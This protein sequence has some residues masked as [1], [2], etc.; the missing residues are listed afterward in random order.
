MAI[1]TAKAVTSRMKSCS[2]HFNASNYIFSELECKKPRLK[3][4]AVPKLRLPMQ[5][6]ISAQARA[7]RVANREAKKRNEKKTN[8]DKYRDCCH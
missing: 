3:K 7:D 8:N 2:L 1:R 5:K 6:M 4:S